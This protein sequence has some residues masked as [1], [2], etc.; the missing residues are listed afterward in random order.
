[1]KW[2]DIVAAMCATRHCKSPV[3]TASVD[4]ISFKSPIQL[5]EIT[6]LQATITRVFNSSLEVFVQVFAESNWQGIRRHCNDAYFTFVSLD[7]KTQKPKKAPPIVPE[8]DEQKFRY[9]RA[10]RRRELRL[11]LAGRMKPEDATDLAKLFGH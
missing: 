10:L 3:V 7:L 8:T 11:I 9:E 5:A 2:M 1:M 4:N 6:E